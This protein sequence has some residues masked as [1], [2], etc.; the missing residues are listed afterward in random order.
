MLLTQEEPIFLRSQIMQSHSYKQIKKKNPVKQMKKLRPRKEWTTVWEP[1]GL[2]VNVEERLLHLETVTAFPRTLH[3]LLVPVSE[4]CVKL[5]L[6][7]TLLWF[8]GHS[9]CKEYL[10]GHVSPAET[11]IHL[12]GKNEKAYL[13][14]TPLCNVPGCFRQYKVCSPGWHMGLDPQRCLG[15]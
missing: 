2:H 8:L 13:I 7:Y 6:I 5:L 9:Q 1:L 4:K 12:Y 14:C 15:T 3:L 11:A 10:V